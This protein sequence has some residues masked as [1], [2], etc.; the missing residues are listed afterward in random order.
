TVNGSFQGRALNSAARLSGLAGP[1]EIL[2]SR[3]FAHLA[4]KVDGVK[5][6]ERGPIRLEGLADPIDVINV[7]PEFED[8]A[9]DV[10]F[11]RALG[12]VAIEVGVGLDAGNP[13]KGL[14]AFEEADAADFFGRELLTAHLIDRL[15][16]GRFLA[17]VGPSGSGKSSV[18][19]AG[20]VPAIRR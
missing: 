14:R 20:L 17:V 1:A 9:Q 19:R 12:P 7:R 3:E 8:L 13:Y 6:V 16:T 2:T 18:V 11:R 15:H 5:Y 4:G 10:A